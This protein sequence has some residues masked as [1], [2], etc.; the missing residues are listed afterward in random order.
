MT[1]FTRMGIT[2]LL[3][4]SGSIAIGAEPDTHEMISEIAESIKNNY[5]FPE[6]GE[7]ASAL[8]LSQL[9]S[10]EYDGLR[11]DVIATQLQTEMRNLM[12]DLHF[13][14]QALPEGWTPPADEDQAIQQGPS[15]PYGFQSVQRLEGN[16]GYIDL[17][18]FTN[19]RYIEETVEASM[20]LL[21]GSSSIIFDLRKNG[22]GDPA[23]VQL[24]SS[25]IF[26]PTE[27]THLNSLYFR[28]SDETTEYWTH[29]G[30][31]TSLAMPDV[32][33]YVLTSSRTFSAAEEFTYN[34]KNLKRATIVGETTGGGAHPVNSFIFDNTLMVVLPI[35]RAINPISGPTGRELACLLI[36]QPRRMTR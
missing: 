14:I 22:G 21:Q 3:A 6:I 4:L 5:V 29:D 20:R 33:V 35:A 17:R 10:G 36:S 2:T 12:H 30:F 7:Q 19:A 31:D 28:P 18:S 9:E 32:P 11:P 34:L 27:P 25:Y 26:D 24:I 23:A 8:I 15:A 1:Q 16:I 13:R